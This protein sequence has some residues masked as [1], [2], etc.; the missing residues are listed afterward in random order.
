MLHYIHITSSPV[1]VDP[2]MTWALQSVPG[3]F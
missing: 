2:M 3:K 1:L